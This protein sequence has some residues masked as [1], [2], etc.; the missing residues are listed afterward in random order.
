[1]RPPRAR[2]RAGGF[3][4]VEMMLAA[5]LMVV[6]AA[7]L[8]A[9]WGAFGRPAV[10]AIAR[11]RLAQEAEIAAESLARDVGMLA[12]S[13][14]TGA[15]SRYQNVQ[16]DGSTLY[17][18]IDDGAGAVRT[19]VYTL[20][21]ADPGRLIRTDSGETRVIARF[22]SGFHAEADTPPVGPGGANVSGVRIELTLSHRVLDRDPDGT[23]RADH[24]RRY[25]LF[26]PD[27][28]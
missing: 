8:S 13:T 5:V 16:A 22:V 15:G 25:T 18:A 7:I 24:T 23:F 20:D 26:V 21:P 19:V 10:S 28:P 1:M 12:A 27:P 4:L 11:A 2:K 14:A 17:L 6:V 9:A 3:T